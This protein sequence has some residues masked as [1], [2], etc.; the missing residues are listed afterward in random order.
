MPI[1]FDIETDE[2]YLEGIAKHQHE[3]VIAMLRDGILSS[4]KI[5]Q[6]AGVTIKYVQ[7][8]KKELESAAKRSN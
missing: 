6:Y 4:E 1:N 8:V 2:L 3:T 5:A 7:K